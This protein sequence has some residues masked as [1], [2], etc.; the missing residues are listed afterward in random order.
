MASKRA[1]AAAV[2][3]L[4]MD[5]ADAER[6]A[7]K[8]LLT[9][10]RVY[11]R[12][13]LELA[14][15]L[16]YATDLPLLS[17]KVLAGLQAEAEDH[18]NRIVAT[19]NADL[20]RHAE[21]VAKL[22]DSKVMGELSRW[23]NA[24]QRKRA[25]P[26]AIT[27]AYSAHAD[28]VVSLYRD[29]GLPDDTLFDFGGRTGDSPPECPICVELYRRGP[30]TLHQVVQ[31]GTPHPQC[32]QSWHLHA[33]EQLP[34]QLPDLGGGLGGIVGKETLITRAGDRDAAAK[35]VVDLAG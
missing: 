17:R 11:R 2:R 32:R 18:A 28:A 15:R 14:S 20:E 5:G 8:L 9:K 16:G 26:I 25:K 10:R 34:P 21:E 24:R 33:Q 27:E 19:F 22:P 23:A 13:L 6:L 7:E 12:T 1:I 35:F 4:R 3:R 31:I 30:W 29:L